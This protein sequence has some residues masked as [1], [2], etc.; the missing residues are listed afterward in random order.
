MELL[1]YWRVIQKSL[2][3]ILLVL[4]VGVGGIIFYTLNRPPEYMS[5]TTLLLVPS[6]STE[7]VQFVQP[8]VASTLADSYSELIRTRSFGQEVAKEIPFQLPGDRLEPFITTHLVPDTTFF[9]IEAIMD[10][11]EGAQQLVGAVVKVLQA[12]I[13]RQQQ[14]G[15]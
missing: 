10:T 6:G 2:W 5:S 9:K 12:T 7:I 11:P 15:N 13:E 4:V 3:L 14:F 1:Q 8:Q